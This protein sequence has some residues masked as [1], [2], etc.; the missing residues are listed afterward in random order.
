MEDL[1]PD[2]QPK[3]RSQKAELW[4]AYIAMSFDA[5]AAV[6]VGVIRHPETLRPNDDHEDIRPP[7]PPKRPNAR[8]GSVALGH[9]FS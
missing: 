8:L 3:T 9:S 5:G 7:K 6:F 1:Q 2:A 4:A